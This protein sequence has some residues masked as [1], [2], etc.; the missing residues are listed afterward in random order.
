MVKCANPEC[1]HHRPTGFLDSLW[2]STGFVNEGR[3]FCSNAC[4]ERFV[5]LGREAEPEA[6]EEAPLDDMTNM[7]LGDILVAYGIIGSDELSSCLKGQ[8]RSDK[9]V[10]QLLVESGLI[11]REAVLAALSKQKGTPWVDV[12]MLS[13]KS[14]ALALLSEEDAQ[15]ERALPFDWT[16]QGQVLVATPDAGDPSRV[17]ELEKKIGHP[18]K[19]VFAPEEDLV[20]AVRQA[21][22]TDRLFDEGAESGRVSPTDRRLGQIMLVEKMITVPQLEQALVEQQKDPSRIGQILVKMGFINEEELARALGKQWGCMC[23]DLASSSIP[24]RTI[25]LFSKEIAYEFM[26][27]P[28]KYSN[29]VLD[30]ATDDPTDRSKFRRLEVRTERRV[31][32]VVCARSQLLLALE[33]Y[34]GPK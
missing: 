13:C 30:V 4:Y 11:P 12:L 15:R 6:E 27:L 7:R 17:A 19:A 16:S 33:K 29:G 8:E 31:K 14:S 2:A 9:R 34:Y 25:N 32:P 10:G 22:S 3:W 1:N 18:V 26:V 24:S 28:V 20:I 21:Y 5:E 23:V